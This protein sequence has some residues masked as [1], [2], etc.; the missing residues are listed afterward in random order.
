MSLDV[1]KNSVVFDHMEVSFL[2]HYKQTD[3][4]M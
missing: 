1:V 2:F 4:F 3:M